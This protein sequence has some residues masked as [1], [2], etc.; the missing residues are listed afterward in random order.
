MNRCIYGPGDFISRDTPFIENMS[1]SHLK[2]FQVNNGT[3]KPLTAKYELYINIL[4]SKLIILNCDFS[5]KV[6]C[7]FLLQKNMYKISDLVKTTI[8]LTL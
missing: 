6:T 5:T 2:Y 7:A 3:L 4:I 1:D 8:S